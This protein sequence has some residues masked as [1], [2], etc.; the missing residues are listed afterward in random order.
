[1]RLEQG[2]EQEAVAG[3]QGGKGQTTKQGSISVVRSQSLDL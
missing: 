2:Q 3:R 1:M